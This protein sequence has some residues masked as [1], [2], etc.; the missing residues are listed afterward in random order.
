MITKNLIRDGIRAKLVQF[1]VDPNLESGTVCQI[2]DS[3]FY[4]GG[5]TA[6]ELS[7]DEYVAEVPE[8]DIVN[9]IF[10]VLDD[11]RKDKELKDEYDY[12]EAI[13]IL[14]CIYRNDP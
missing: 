7:P 9:E 12:Y 2:G 6:E 10:E 3:W 13:L 14:V 1:V 4:F 11:F 8:D 5:L